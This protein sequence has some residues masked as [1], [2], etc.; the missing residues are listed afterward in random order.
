VEVQIFWDRT[1]AIQNGFMGIETIY[2]NM[3]F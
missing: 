2:N 1:R 3:T